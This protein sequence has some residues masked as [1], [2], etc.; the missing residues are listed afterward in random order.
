MLTGKTITIAVRGQFMVYAALTT[1][2]IA[3]AYDIPLPT[4]LDE[5]SRTLDEPDDEQEDVPYNEN[6]GEVFLIAVAILLFLVVIIAY[7]IGLPFYWEKCRILSCFLLLIGNWLLINVCFHFYMAATTN[8]GYLKNDNDI[9]QVVSVCKKCIAPKPPRTH[10][11]SFCD[12]CVLKM[13]H[14]CPWLNNCVGHFNHRYFFLF[15]CY[16]AI[17]TLFIIIFGVE[18]LFLEF[19]ADTDYDYETFGNMSEKA[20]FAAKNQTETNILVT[21]FYQFA[22]FTMGSKTTVNENRPLSQNSTDYIE[23][24]YSRMY[25]VCVIFEFLL[26][27]GAFFAVTALSIWHAKLIIRG[28]TSIERHINAKERKKYDVYKNP[29]DF[30]SRNNMLIFLGLT[31]G[32]SW[33][34]HLILPST[35]TPEGNGLTWKTNYR[36]HNSNE[37]KNAKQES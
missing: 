12:Q 19:W 8:P 18:I 21:I 15:C 24:N 7:L 1:M 27:T 35:H 31:N 26:T 32:R 33:F 29:Y 34:W 14:H 3:N 4:I 17:G 36:Y 20:N 5:D 16:T 11:C 9:Q 2:L 13:D 30:G 37:P 23:E 25:R 28:E 6:N 10:H 22:V